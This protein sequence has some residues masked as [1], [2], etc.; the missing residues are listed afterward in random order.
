MRAWHW[1]FNFSSRQ[2]SNNRSDP[3]KK[4]SNGNDPFSLYHSLSTYLYHHKKISILAISGLKIDK[5]RDQYNWST[6]T[7][8]IDNLRSKPIDV[9]IQT[10]IFAE[11]L[12][13]YLMNNLMNPFNCPNS[14]WKTKTQKMMHT[15]NRKT[16]SILSRLEHRRAQH[17]QF[18]QRTAGTHNYRKLNFRYN[19]FLHRMKQ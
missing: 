18:H 14:T 3:S 2:C 9:L 16:G 12:N 19:I 1:N 5:T 6:S 10:A 13:Q 17:Q 4:T 11:E 8:N 7:G 15:R